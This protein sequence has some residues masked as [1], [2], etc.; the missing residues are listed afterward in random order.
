VAAVEPVRDRD[1]ARAGDPAPEAGLIEPEMEA[2]EA[3]RAKE[4]APATTRGG[5]KP[6]KTK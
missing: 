3:E 4:E 5:R 2:Y 6:R 1:P